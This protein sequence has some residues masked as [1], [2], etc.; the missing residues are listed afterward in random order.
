MRR[1]ILRKPLRETLATPRRAKLQA[2]LPAQLP[3]EINCAYD[4][5]MSERT[6]ADAIEGD[7][8]I[9]RVDFRRS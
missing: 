3:W 5:T 1:A 2:V 4:P 9:E 7:G 6:K 8:F